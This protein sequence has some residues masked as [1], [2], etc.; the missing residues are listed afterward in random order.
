MTPLAAVAQLMAEARAAGD[1][2]LDHSA[3]LRGVER[4]SGRLTL[5]AGDGRPRTTTVAR[6]LEGIAA[7]F[8]AR[9][10]LE[11]DCILANPGRGRWSTTQSARIASANEAEE[12]AYLLHERVGSLEGGEVTTPPGP[13]VP[14]EIGEAAFGPAA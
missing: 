5:P 6:W 13:L 2:S 4:L 3:V 14:A 10:V 12:S 11:A 8:R 1:G 9:D 7:F